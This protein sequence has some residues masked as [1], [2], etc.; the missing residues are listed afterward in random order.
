M[1]TEPKFQGKMVVILAGY[2]AQMEQLLAVNPGLRSRFSEK[3]F[4]PDFSIE[5]ACNLLVKAIDKEHSLRLDKE[6][7]EQLPLLMAQLVQA[8]GWSNGRD[9]DNW[10]KSIFRK[11]CTRVGG[12][13]MMSQGASAGEQLGEPEEIAL[14]DLRA[15]LQEC[16]TKKAGGLTSGGSIWV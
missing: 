12:G 8:P 2:E 5:D 13:E 6:A 16:L 1:L 7:Q 11:Y 3:M 9:V 14:P 15:S 10:R 4:F